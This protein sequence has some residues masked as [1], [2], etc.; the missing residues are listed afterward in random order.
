MGEIH[1][2][3]PITV[4]SICQFSIDVQSLPEK[5]RLLF[6]A[7]ADQFITPT[8]LIC[9]TKIC[10]RRVRASENEKCS[11]SGLANYGYANNLGFSD[12][13][14]LI[15]RPFPQGAFG[16]QTYVPISRL[17][18]SDLELRAAEKFCHVGDVIEDNCLPIA[19]RISQGLSE[20]LTIIISRLLREIFRNTFEHSEADLCGY[21]AQY[22]P[23]ME[24]VEFCIADRGM[25][26]RR[27]LS[28]N[29]YLQ[30]ASDADALQLAVMPGLS[31][32]AWR[33]KK[34][35]SAQK[36]E[37]DN[38]GFGLFQAYRLFGSLGT[39]M[40]ASG[41]AAIVFERGSRTKILPCDFEGTVVSARLNLSDIAAIESTIESIVRDA[42]EVKARIG[43]KSVD[44]GSVQT[45]LGLDLDP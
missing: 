8:G 17:L 15:D 24:E 37:W 40:I 32:K 23:R 45:Y 25:G 35:K 30:I 7:G 29:K 13:L 44:L 19:K 16:G 42:A 33:H 10:N 12:A 14:N 28:E 34:K 1:F 11:Y 22:W 5:E 38:A 41:S 27:S 9:L 43:T 2:P 21:S 3:R 39:L 18:R 36:S 4:D 6:I 31:S 26:I 20:R